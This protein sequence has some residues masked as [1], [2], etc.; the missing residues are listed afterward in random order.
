MPRSLE[1]IHGGHFKQQAMLSPG[2][3]KVL[4]AVPLEAIAY[5][6]TARDSTSSGVR[7]ESRLHG[8]YRYQK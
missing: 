4:Q 2:G 8:G 6:G 7:P 5:A 3:A 1:Q